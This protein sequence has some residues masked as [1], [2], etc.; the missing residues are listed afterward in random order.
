MATL[1]KSPSQP[2]RKDNTTVQS[3]KLPDRQFDPKR[4]VERKGQ[5]IMKRWE[6]AGATGEHHE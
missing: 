3:Q 4:T 5:Y 6:E 1:S 2:V